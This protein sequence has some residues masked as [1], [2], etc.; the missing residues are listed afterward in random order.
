M[1]YEK[2]KLKEARDAV[3]KM[4]IVTSLNKVE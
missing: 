4:A 1:P 3:C 2:M